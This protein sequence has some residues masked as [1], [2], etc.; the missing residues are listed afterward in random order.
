MKTLPIDAGHCSTL[1]EL[2]RYRAAQQP[3]RSAYTFL[4]DG[5]KEEIKMTYAD[6]DRGARKIAGR[7]Q[8][9]GAEG[10]RA[11]LLYPPGLEYITA[12]FG[13]LYAGVTAMPAFPP[14]PNRPMPR[15]QGMVA[16]AQ[17]K[18]ALAPTSVL[19]NLEQRFTQT[20]ELRDL[21][22]LNTDNL[23]DGFEANW[24]PPAISTDSLAF[25]QYTSA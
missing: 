24:A 3:D 10:E 23:P 2:L 8:S 12:F 22:W 15:L 14:R 16:D 1:V 21:H 11:L 18:V 5:A 7:L 19:D 4:M 17:V 6:L 13:C 25:L 20:P 9:L